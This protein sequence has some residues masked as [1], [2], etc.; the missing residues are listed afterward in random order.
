M[1]WN[2]LPIF[3]AIAPVVSAKVPLGVI[4]RPGKMTKERKN[5][6]Q[7]NKT[8]MEPFLCFLFF[9]LNQTHPFSLLLLLF[10]LIEV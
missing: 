5:I 7:N 9:F 4:F 6:M 2:G 1:G 3:L 10:F 8:E